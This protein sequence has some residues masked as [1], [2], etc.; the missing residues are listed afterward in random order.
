MF[1]EVILPVINETFKITIP[2]EIKDRFITDDL[3]AIVYLDI[4]GSKVIAS[5]NFRYGNVEF[6]SFESPSKRLYNFKTSFR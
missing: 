4:E 5:L 6:N 3:E 1:L 2:D